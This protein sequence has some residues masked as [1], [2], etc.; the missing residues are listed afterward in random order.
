V[1]RRQIVGFYD[2]CFL[3]AHRVKAYFPC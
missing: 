3:K 2:F 1:T